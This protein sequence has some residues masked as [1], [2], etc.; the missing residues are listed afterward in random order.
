VCNGGKVSFF[1]IR[2][3]TSA[4]LVKKNLKALGF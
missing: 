3:G 2:A 4:T 1:P